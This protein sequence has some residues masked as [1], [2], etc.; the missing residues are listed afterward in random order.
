MSSF[1]TRLLFYVRMIAFSLFVFFI[2]AMNGCVKT[3]PSISNLDHSEMGGAGQL[4]LHLPMASNLS[5]QCT[6]GAFDRYSHNAVCTRYDIDLDTSNNRNESVF[7]PIGGTVYVHEEDPATGFGRHVC[8]DL[9]NGTYVVLGHLSQIVVRNGQEISVGQFLGYEGC[10]GNCSGDHIHIGLHRGDAQLSAENG[11]SIPATYLIKDP[12]VQSGM[13]TLGSEDFHCGLVAAGDAE[14]G[15]YYSSVLEPARFHPDGT[16]V[17]T[18]GDPRVYRLEESRTRWITD[19]TVFHSYGYSFEN[20]IT[21]SNEESSCYGR[22]DPINQQGMVRALQDQDGNV[23]LLV[24]PR[25]REDRYRMRVRVRALQEVLSSWGISLDRTPL[26]S[27]NSQDASLTDWPIR[28]GFANFREG[29]LVKEHSSS[30]VFVI[31]TSVPM[32]VRD[33]ETFVL[34]DYQSQ[35]IIELN[36]GDLASLYD[37]IGSCQIPSMCLS[38]DA[39]R[40][41]GGNFRQGNMGGPVQNEPEPHAPESEPEFMIDPDAQVEAPVNDAQVRSDSQQDAGVPVPDD[42]PPAPDDLDEEPVEEN[43][44]DRCDEYACI[45]DADEDGRDETLILSDDIWIQDSLSTLDVFVYSNGGCFDGTLSAEDL[46][47][48]ENDY[49]FIDFSRFDHLCHSELTLIS[50][51][52]TDGLP[53]DDHMGN[54]NWWQTGEFCTSS[55]QLCELMNNDRQ[56]E[57]WLLA[58]AWDPVR[59]LVPNGNGYTLN[60]QL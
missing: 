27:V 12:T 43:E 34:L 20:V 48:S 25:A 56:W 30:D 59:G 16:L 40:V 31:S 7:A 4:V 57:E 11:E 58:V 5:L 35:S 21:I 8:I 47:H 29:T 3:N 39:V 51:V 18:L 15:S 55:S 9:G 42:D 52:G 6:Q 46:V 10:T 50:S 2:I 26:I 38:L 33:W 22:G 41:C 54:W 23:W 49:Y 60:A 1:P 53:P 32:P 13:S 24:G 19:E 17:K 45:I 37:S 14:N 36:Q 28:N 44:V